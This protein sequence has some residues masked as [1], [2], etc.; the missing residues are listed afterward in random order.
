MEQLHDTAKPPLSMPKLRALAFAL[1]AKREYSKFTLYR[2]LLQHG[3]DPQQ[4]EQLIEE[5]A[6][7]HYQSDERM[8]EMLIRSQVRQG[9]GPQRIQQEIKKHQLN[10]ALAQQEMQH[11]N[12]LQQA[13]DLKI[14]KFG[15][16]I[17]KDPKIKAKQ[18][19][20]LQY[21]GFTMDVIMK[22]INGNAETDEEFWIE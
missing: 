15:R 7:A 9:R 19:R 14:R 8:T 22:V 17:A 11:I 21:R 10:P 6:Q 13:M 5:L 18:I 1:L 4:A 3:A 12:W 16:E 2:K 20:F